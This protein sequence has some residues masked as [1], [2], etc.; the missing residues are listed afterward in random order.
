MISRMLSTPVFDAASKFDGDREAPG[1]DVLAS[2]ADATRRR[3]NASFRNS[4]FSQEC[5]R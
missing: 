5:A 2:L 4:A 1:I 3:S